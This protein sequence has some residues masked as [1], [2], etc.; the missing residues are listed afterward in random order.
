MAAGSWQDFDTLESFIARQQ[1]LYPHSRGKFSDILRRI[2]LG[3]KIIASK[4]RMAGLVDV[5]GKQGTSNVQGEEQ[6]K[7]DVIANQIIKSVL[8]WVTSVAAIASEEDEK[9][10]ILHHYEEIKE[11][12]YV[13]FYDP[14]DGSSNIDVNVSVGTIF[15][16]YRYPYNQPRPPLERYFLPGSQQVA[17]GYVV[18][19]SSAMFV[20]T[21]GQ[22]VHGFTLD[23]EIGEFV[24][25]HENIRTPDVCTYYS[26][27]DTYYPQW[28]EAV[29]KF[30][31][32]LRFSDEPRYAKTTCRY[33]GSLVADFHRNLLGGGVFMYPENPSAPH[34][35]LR[36]LYE[37]A[38][39]AMIAEQA[40]GKASTGRERILDVQ[41]SDV[42]QRVPFFVGCR[43]DIEL[44]EQLVRQMD[45]G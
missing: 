21:T 45:A 13:V 8:G 16:I 43:Q 18:Y 14:V 28:S 30:S 29:R 36:L 27:N 32:M 1:R 42:H 7:L 31:D 10:T 33:V 22:G 17:A 24:L 26:A 37:C 9:I 38:P 4:V 15:S 19:G 41:P 25:S 2:G 34:G 6:M 3:S 23:P 12:Q 39:L 5:L 11:D 44:Y 40:G 20:Y 35:K